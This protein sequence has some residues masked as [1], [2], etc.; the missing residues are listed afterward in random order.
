MWQGYEPAAAQLLPQ[1]VAESTTDARWPAPVPA[2]AWPPWWS[3]HHQL[4]SGLPYDTQPVYLP[5][6]Q[7][8]APIHDY[9]VPFT[10]PMVSYVPADYQVPAPY[11]EFGPMPPYPMPPIVALVTDASTQLVR[12]TSPQVQPPVQ[13]LAE[14][15]P[16]QDMQA[17]QGDALPAVWLT[18]EQL[19]LE[20]GLELATGLELESGAELVPWLEFAP[21]E[22]LPKLVSESEPVKVSVDNNR[23]HIYGICQ[24]EAPEVFRISEG[25]SLHYTGNVPANLAAKAR[26]AVRCC[27]MQAIAISG[28]A[29]PAP[30]R[31]SRR[32]RGATASRDGYRRIVVAGGGLAGL[33]AASRLRERGFD[34]ELVLVGEE[35]RRPYSRPPLS[36]QFL[37]G[38]SGSEDL[39]FRADDSLDAHWLLGTHMIGLDPEKKT[40]KLRGGERLP[41]DGLVIATG[42]DAK[43]L[44][45]APV[46]SER[47]RTVRTLADAAAIQ[48]AMHAAQAHHVVILGGGFVGCELACTARDQGM[49]V[50]L[51]V[52]SAPLLRRVL[53]GKLG[54]VV[55]RIQARAGVDVR[56]STTINEWTDTGSGLRLRLDDGEVIDADFVV[57]GLGSVPRTEWLHGSGLDVTDG[58]L[59]DTTCHAV[60]LTGRPVPGIVAAGDVARWPNERFDS[61]PRRVEHLIHAVEMGQH[62]AD[63]LL[64][65]PA[66]AEMFTPVPRF[67]SE[68]HGTRLQA[69]GMPA[70]GE[71]MEIVEGSL[72]SESFVAAYKRDTPQGTQLVAAVA[73]DMPRQ[74]LDYRDRIG[75]T[76]PLAQTPTPSTRRRR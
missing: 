30:A 53:G 25:G 35:L 13:P 33:S 24:Q 12:W 39:T 72:R 32:S 36:K 66:E 43:R 23:C 55:G 2:G 54:E 51:V 40:L 5:P 70:L 50:T 59:C 20:T 4:T 1:G 17:L 22:F 28:G 29:A 58:V 42:V 41:Y 62:A 11:S 71:R 15:Y 65:G 44:P 9:Q 18:P 14:R 45:Q 56:L 6:P 76:G 74:L 3:G 10:N 52:H 19:E 26:Q 34:G 64:Q 38:E 61:T 37:A 8:S 46:L 63:S 68:Q 7:L 73:F 47:I 16:V 57:L 67:W 27:P 48:Q 60:D 21:E 31:R 49:D 69:V 75:H